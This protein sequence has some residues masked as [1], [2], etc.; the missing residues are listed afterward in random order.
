MV[1]MTRV[2]FVLTLGLLAPMALSTGSH[3]QERR[4]SPAGQAATQVGGYYDARSGFVNGAWIEMH[5]GR[6]LKRGRNIFGTDDY[7]EFL[8]DGA[9]VWRAGANASTRLITEVPLIF[10]ATT[11]AAGGYTVF[12]DLDATPW[13]FILSNWQAQVGYDADNHDALYGAFE[14]TADRDVVRVPMSIETRSHSYEQ[15]SWQFL[16]V[17]ETGGTLALLWDSTMASVPFAL[18]E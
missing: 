1:T 14:F 13:T 6:P 17:T 16:D 3:A 2:K 8:N 11:V 12:I 18:A 10:G 15:L 9:P 7:R 4:A 5:Y